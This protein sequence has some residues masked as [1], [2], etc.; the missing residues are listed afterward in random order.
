MSRR[1]YLKAVYFYSNFYFFSDAHSLLYEQMFDI[2]KFLVTISD[3]SNSTIVLLHAKSNGIY[4]VFDF[5][6]FVSNL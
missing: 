4:I 2:K 3:I 6:G 1:S 5:F